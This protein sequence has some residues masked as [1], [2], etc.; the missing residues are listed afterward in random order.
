MRAG[1]DVDG[2]L[3][4]IALVQILCTLFPGRRER[5]GGYIVAAG[6]RVVAAPVRQWRVVDPLE[7]VVRVGL[8]KRRWILGRVGGRHR[9]ED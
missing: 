4:R 9:H 2:I 5:H 7:V 3:L 1:D 8:E 6:A